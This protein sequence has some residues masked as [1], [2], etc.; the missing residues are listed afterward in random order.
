MRS[1]LSISAL[2]LAATPAL[3]QEAAQGPT[4]PLTPPPLQAQAQPPTQRVLTLAEA[5]SI[6]QERQPQL[7]QA[8]ASTTAA[9]A[10][11][12]QSFAPLLPQVNANASYQ[13]SFSPNTSFG[14][15]DP[16][17]GIIRREG[18]NAGLSVNQLIWDFGR[19]TGRWRVSQQNA[20]A[21]ANT[22]EQTQS[23]V[24]ANV[25]TT[26]FN[27]LAQQALV[28][29]AEETLQNQQSHLDQVRAQVQVG[30]R[31]EIDLL[32]Q[33]TLVANARLQLIQAR[34]N[35]ATLK[36]QLNQ[37]MGLEGPTDYAVREEVIALV[38]GEDSPAGTL[39]DTAFGNRAYLAATDHQLLVDMNHGCSCSHPGLKAL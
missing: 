6:A 12:D 37:A 22:E 3:A 17:S 34:N 26:Y 1:F 31:A 33:Q 5:L 29:V 30:T 11:V 15:A 10:R 27:A 13:R 18:F 25:Q 35:S 20:A 23:N 8:Q 14:T 36:A 7:R 38:Q 24:L 19:T 16:S 21:Q 39:V 4:P 28:Q 2:L 32:Q 9:N